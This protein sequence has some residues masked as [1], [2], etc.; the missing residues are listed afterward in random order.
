M[1]QQNAWD[2]HPLPLP[3]PRPCS[4]VYSQDENPFGDNFSLEDLADKVN[5]FEKSSES[6]TLAHL[7]RENQTLY[8]NVTFYRR[9]WDALMHLLDEL[10]D[11]NLLIR[12]TLKD[13]NDKIT[14]A[15]AAWLAFWGIV[16]S[17]HE[18]NWI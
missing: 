9:E 5:E 17:S 15:K 1:S 12:S 4:S 8:Q 6:N 13:C 16:E 3:G 2:L 10:M 18:N 7:V 14:E 11:S